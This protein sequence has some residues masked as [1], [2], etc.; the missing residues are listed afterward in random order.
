MNKYDR[1]LGGLTIFSNIF[2]NISIHLTFNIYSD[3]HF[4]YSTVIIYVHL[5][6]IVS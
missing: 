1:D 5:R 2:D 3:G 4:N 6:P